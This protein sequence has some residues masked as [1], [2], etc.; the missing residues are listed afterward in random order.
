MAPLQSPSRRR[1]RSPNGEQLPWGF[2]SPSRL[3][4]AE[5]TDRRAFPCSPTFRPQR[6][7]RSRWFPPP[8]ALWACFIPLPRT[9]FRS[10]GVFPA[11]E[12]DW[13]LASRSPLAVQYN[14]PSRTCAR[15][16]FG[17]PR[18]QGFVPGSDP[19]RV[20]GGLDLSLPDPLLSF[21]LPRVCLRLP[22]SR[23]RSTSAP[24]LGPRSLR[25]VTDA[26]LQRIDRQC[27]LCDLSPGREPVR[28]FMAVFRSPP[29]RRVPARPGQPATHQDRRAQRRNVAE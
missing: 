17:R 26:G 2:S 24:G 7:S 6:F 22:R 9:G 21:Q 13:L 20:K 4:H 5:S 29:R 3:Q 10:S 28:V 25:V 8:R 15:V 1:S 16:Q 19:L 14:R 18:L 23:L 11:A 12:L 27:D